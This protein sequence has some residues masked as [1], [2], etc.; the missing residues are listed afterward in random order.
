[1]TV[2]LHFLSLLEFCSICSES[3]D[4]ALYLWL[5]SVLCYTIVSKQYVLF[6]FAASL[7]VGLCNFLRLEPLL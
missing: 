2:F 4:D 5:C 7:W 6:L 3:D 1:M